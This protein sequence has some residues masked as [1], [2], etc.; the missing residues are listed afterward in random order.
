MALWNGGEYGGIGQ[1]DRNDEIRK[2]G[3]LRG[4]CNAISA[5]KRLVNENTDKIEQTA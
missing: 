5:S 3:H 1:G 2:M 4:N